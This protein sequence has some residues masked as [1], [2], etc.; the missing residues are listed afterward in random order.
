MTA[1]LDAF[2][3]GQYYTFYT[4]P[5]IP[6]DPI[7]PPIYSAS[8]L[9]GVPANAVGLPMWVGSSNK[10]FTITSTMSAEVV[11]GDIWGGSVVDLVYRGGNMYMSWD[12]IAFKAATLVP[13]WPW[14]VIGSMGTIGRLGSGVGGAIVMTA[15]PLTPA[16]GLPSIGQVIIQSITAPNAIL[17]ENFNA[18]LFFDSRLRKVPIRLRLLPFFDRLVTINQNPIPANFSVAQ[19]GLVVNGVQQ[20]VATMVPAAIPGASAYSMF[21]VASYKWYSI[22]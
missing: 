3:A 19:A 15:A 7:N 8:G 14:N 18:E 11:E 21:N 13:F 16:A 1:P 5:V 4:M 2:V 9:N 10:G 17:A 12:A 20:I 22:L 6:G